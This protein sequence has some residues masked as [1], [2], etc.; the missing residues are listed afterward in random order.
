MNPNGSTPAIDWASMPEWITIDE[1]ADLSQYNPD[2][3]RRLA[4]K[5]RLGAAKKG[6]DWWIDRD[7][8][9]AYL[10]DPPPRG[11]PATETMT[12]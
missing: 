3:L 12:D 6:R 11:R 7:A 8:L 2:Y 5:G 4:R 1:A 9:Q 10:E